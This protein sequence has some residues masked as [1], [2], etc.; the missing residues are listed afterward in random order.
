MSGER[1]DQFGVL[2]QCRR[3][4]GQRL[5]HPAAQHLFEQWQHLVAKP[6]SGESGIGVVRV[7]PRGKAQLPARGVRGGPPDTQQGPAPRRI[8]RPH[9]SDRA[10]AGTSAQTQQHRLRLI[11]EGVS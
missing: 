2:A 3:G 8:V 4:A 5:G 7:L 6:G 11:V 1:V 10:R 9:P